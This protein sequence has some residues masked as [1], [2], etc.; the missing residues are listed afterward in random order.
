MGRILSCYVVV[1]LELLKTVENKFDI[2]AVCVSLVIR[3]LRVGCPFGPQKSFYGGNSLTN[4]HLSIQTI[5]KLSH[6]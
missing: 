6:S 4:V 3:R 5:S 1:E 2:C